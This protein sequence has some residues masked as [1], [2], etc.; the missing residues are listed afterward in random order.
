MGTRWRPVTTTTI[1]QQSPATWGCVSGEGQMRNLE[2]GERKPVVECCRECEE[3]VAGLKI[4]GI[5]GI[6]ENS[7]LNVVLYE[8]IRNI[9]I[10][11]NSL[12]V[13]QN[14]TSL[15]IEIVIFISSD[16]CGRFISQ[17]YI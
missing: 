10:L 2:Q 8:R 4:V 1:L 14:S 12:F 7:T 3:V 15:Y 16:L 6:Y 9:E 11:G 5:N 13:A 17:Q